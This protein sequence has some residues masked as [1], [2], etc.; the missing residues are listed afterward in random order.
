MGACDLKLD[1]LFQRFYLFGLLVELLLVVSQ[2]VA[3]CRSIIIL[4]TIVWREILLSQD[5]LTRK[6]K[7]RC[8]INLKMNKIE[9]QRTILKPQP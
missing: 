9:R 8:A 4:D 1:L 6:L 3:S 7:I 5:L 2:P